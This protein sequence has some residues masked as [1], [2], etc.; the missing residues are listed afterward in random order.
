MAQIKI[1]KIVVNPKKQSAPKRRNP[2][3][4]LVGNLNPRRNMKRKKTKSNPRLKR[5]TVVALRR[6]RN[7]L[8]VRPRRANPNGVVDTP[9]RLLKTGTLALIGLVATRQV[10]QMLLGARN[11]GILGYVANAAAALASAAVARKV[12]DREAAEAVGIGGALYLANRIISEQLTPVGK[13]L[14]LTG[15]GDAQAAGLGAVG[16]Y[17][18]AYFPH[19]VVTDRA[20]GKPVIPQAIRDA[21][22]EQAEQVVASRAPAPPAARLAGLRLN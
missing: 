17:V 1:R 15:V 2:Y 20:T 19:P 13:V 22:R 6:R 8:F 11:A 21:A 5:R 9:V 18:P 16:K 14:S 12:A 4:T 7:P 10:P 3:L